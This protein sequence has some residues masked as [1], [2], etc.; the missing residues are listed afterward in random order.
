MRAGVGL[1]RLRFSR[2][3]S[4][5]TCTRPACRGSPTRG[6]PGPRT[7]Q[8]PDPSCERVCHAAYFAQ[9]LGHCR[10][11]TAVTWLAGM[12]LPHVSS[13]RPG[14]GDDSDFERSQ[15]STSIDVPLNAPISAQFFICTAINSCLELFQVS[16]AV[17]PRAR[18][19]GE[20]RHI[21]MDWMDVVGEFWWCGIGLDGGGE[22]VP[23]RRERQ[24]RA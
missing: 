10:G 21:D 19:T 17:I 18:V 9:A 24:Q 12:P 3:S 13:D 5:D 7:R 4:E 20:Q 1:R 11:K 6:F 2:A 15:C 23:R 14:T 8:S 22:V 16:M